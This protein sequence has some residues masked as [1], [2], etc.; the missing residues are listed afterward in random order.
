MEET[1]ADDESISECTLAASLVCNTHMVT[2]EQSAKQLLQLLLGAEVAAV[3]ALLLTAVVGTLGQTGVALAANHLLA[4]VLLGESSKRGLDDSS[5]QLEQN[6]HSGVLSDVVVADGLGVLQL[7]SSEHH[8]LVV[9]IN[10]LLLL[11]HLLDVLHL[12]S[13]LDLERDGI[14]LNIVRWTFTDGSFTSL[15]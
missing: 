12:L 9:V 2:I 10:V 4:V 5:S 14:S 3:T 15:Q 8:A 13:G 11:D 7:L 1:V 6:L